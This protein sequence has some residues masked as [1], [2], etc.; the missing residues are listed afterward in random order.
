MS[1]QPFINAGVYIFLGAFSIGIFYLFA[2]MFYNEYKRLLNLNQ[3]PKE[4]EEEK[5][6]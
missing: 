5:K 1:I 4:E 6:E 3:K 2:R